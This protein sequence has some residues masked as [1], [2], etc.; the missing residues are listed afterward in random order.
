MLL[1][2]MKPLFKYVL[3]LALA[4]PT[5]VSFAQAFNPVGTWRTRL[6]AEV[7]IDRCGQQF[8]GVVT[9]AAKPGLTDSAIQTQA[10]AIAQLK[11]FC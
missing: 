7:R 2:A 9:K 10:Y 4:L 3:A 8:C 5:T 6:D 1:T 11:A